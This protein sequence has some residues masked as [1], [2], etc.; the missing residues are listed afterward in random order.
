MLLGHS[1]LNVTPVYLQFKESDLKAVYDAV[2][3]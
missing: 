3:F 2:A 1:S